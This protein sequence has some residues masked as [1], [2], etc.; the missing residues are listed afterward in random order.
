MTTPQSFDLACVLCMQAAGLETEHNKLQAVHSTL[1]QKLSVAEQVLP[2][3]F[4]KIAAADT[5]GTPVTPAFVLQLDP[6]ASCASAGSSVMLIA[7]NVVVAYASFSAWSTTAAF[8][9]TST[10]TNPPP[11]PPLSSTA[12]TLWSQSSATVCATY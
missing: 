11:A 2:P 5:T 3:L 9:T 10:S 8:S 12:G 1:E 7:G 4:V 6:T